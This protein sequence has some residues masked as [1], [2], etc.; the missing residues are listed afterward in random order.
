MPAP[1]TLSLLTK[2][3]AA[4]TNWIRRRLSPV[5]HH[6]RTVRQKR[7]WMFPPR[8]YDRRQPGHRTKYKRKKTM[9]KLSALT[10][11]LLMTIAFMVAP[12]AQAGD[13]DASKAPGILPSGYS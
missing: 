10:E 6:L 8:D 1:S 13:K 5:R 3:P 9:R 12:V 2:W 7:L 11:F 4:V